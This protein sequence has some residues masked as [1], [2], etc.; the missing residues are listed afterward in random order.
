MGCGPEF[1]EFLKALRGTLGANQSIGKTLGLGRGVWESYEQ[2]RR[3]P[4]IDTLFTLAAKL[5]AR[6][7]HHRVPSQAQFLAEWLAAQDVDVDAALLR[8][9]R[10]QGALRVSLADL[11]WLNPYV[12]IGER[13]EVR[14]RTRLDA[15]VEPA[16]S[17]DLHWICGLGLDPSTEVI[18]D[19]ELSLRPWDELV[20]RYGDRDVV[21]LSSG[22]VNAMTGLLVGDMVFRVDAMAEARAAY[23]SFV[24]T[25]DHLED[26]DLLLAFQACLAAAD[27]LG[28]SG[29]AE[30]LLEKAGL[31]RESLSVAED[32]AE[33]LGGSTPSQFTS[34]FRQGFLDPVMRRRYQPER[35]DDYAV[36]SF[37]RH[38]F[39]AEDKVAL[40][41]AGTNG[42]ATSG[43][44][45]LM[46][47]EGIEAWPLGA[48]VRVSQSAG[49]WSPAE[50]VTNP[51]T[52]QELIRS[53]DQI[54]EAPPSGRRTMLRGVFGNWTDQD[55][56]DW[57]QLVNDLAAIMERR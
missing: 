56:R 52:P 5:A 38:P 54:L 28:S 55:L 35:E 2:G 53:I 6:F 33:L 46:A 12:F 30:A 25:M 18:G 39:G 37:A 4:E 40:V 41:I 47:T 14:A 16:A 51:Y 3:L 44:I 23:R 57:K 20:R 21:S 43:A 1:G 27:L 48:I 50:V 11:A 29:D 36:I 7:P 9:L 17:S 24:R 26:R 45:R 42:P 34:L 32:V 22:A 13:R 15:L 8:S 10:R 31:G 19:K 49:G